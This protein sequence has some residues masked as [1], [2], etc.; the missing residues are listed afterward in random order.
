MSTIGRVRRISTILPTRS[1]DV[2]GA[3]VVVRSTTSLPNSGSPNQIFD[4][5][6]DGQICFGVARW[7]VQFDYLYGDLREFVKQHE[8]HDTPSDSG[9]VG[10]GVTYNII[11]C[12]KEGTRLRS[13]LR[14]GPYTT[15]KGLIDELRREVRNAREGVREFG[16]Y[17]KRL[18][19]PTNPPEFSWFV[20][21]QCSRDDLPALDEVEH[22]LH[23]F[24]APSDAQYLSRTRVMITDYKP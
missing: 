1:C 16:V 13:I 8:S 10:E 14:C 6:V 21:R 20:G 5:L 7:W 19:V 4:S 3:K 2:V 9:L 22:V 15:T 24:G 12:K 23:K 18:H 17:E 11:I